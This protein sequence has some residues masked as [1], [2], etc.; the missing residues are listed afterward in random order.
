[1][2]KLSSRLNLT[3]LDYD[4]EEELRERFNQAQQR[5]KS[6]LISLAVERMILNELIHKYQ[7]IEM[8]KIMKLNIKRFASARKSLDLFEDQ[9][10]VKHLIM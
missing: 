9:D 8:P 2:T 6:S 3:F 10:A 7:N 4:S 5:R 1:M